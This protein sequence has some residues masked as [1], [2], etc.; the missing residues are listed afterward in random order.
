[1]GKNVELVLDGYIAQILEC[2]DAYDPTTLRGMPE[3]ALIAL[4]GELTPQPQDN[5]LQREV[6]EANDLNKKMLRAFRQTRDKP[7]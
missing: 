4:L 6:R 3:E 1:M 7:Y 2:T 5:E